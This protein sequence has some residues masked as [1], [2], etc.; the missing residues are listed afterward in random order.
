MKFVVA[1]E[2]LSKLLQS[3]GKLVP[4]SDNL[5]PIR[6]FFLLEVANGSLYLTATDGVI[7][8]RGVIPTIE[9]EGEGTF[10][11]RPKDLDYIKDLADQPLT[12]EYRPEEKML[13]MHFSSGY[14]SY[15]TSDADL[16]PQ[17][18]AQSEDFVHTTTMKS[19][20]LLK[21]IESVIN[22]IAAD[23]SRPILASLHFAF[24]PTYMDVVGTTTEILTKYTHYG[25]AD[26]NIVDSTDVRVPS[27]YQLCM[28]Q[29]MANFLRSILPRFGE[30]IAEVSF[31]QRRIY[32]RLSNMQ[33]SSLLVEG[34]YPNY[35]NVIPKDNPHKVAMDQKQ[36]LNSLKRIESFMNVEQQK[37]HVML[38]FEG[39]TLTLQSTSG[40]K[41]RVVE[42]K[43]G[44]ENSTSL[45]I[46]I[47]FGIRNLISLIQT[48]STEQV[49]F[50]IADATRPML[51]IPAQNPEESE[52]C[53][54]I[55]PSALLR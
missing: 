45:Q 26:A 19:S 2:E 52:Q 14:I 43:I 20:I 40:G 8:S 55:M 42:E 1:Q 22:S 46:T 27:P 11:V 18:D 21:G 9:C 12:F 16:Y 37:A 44:V 32:L 25:V 33:I 17:D 36:L 10:A 7:R 24:K 6:T 28:P 29:K 47:L 23:T 51:I 41:D 54:V 53:S 15:S 49:V 13:D 4:S 38:I 3:Q 30:E 50:E 5:V 48:I 39:D 31:T 34:R 35:N